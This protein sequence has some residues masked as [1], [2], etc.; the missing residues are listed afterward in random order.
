VQ[1]RGI[2][3]LVDSGF[4]FIYDGSTFAYKITFKSVPGTKPGPKTTTVMFFLFTKQVVFGRGLNSDFLS[5]NLLML[6]FSK[7]LKPMVL[8]HLLYQDDNTF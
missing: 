3:L 6:C 4:L 8:R 7:F 5:F 2:L 1:D